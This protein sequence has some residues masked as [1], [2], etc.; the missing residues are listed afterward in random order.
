M[1]RKFATGFS[2]SL[3]VKDVGIAGDLSAAVD[4][5]TPLLSL[6][7][8]IW[9]EGRDEIGADEDNSAVVKLWE[10]R[11]GVTIES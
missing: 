10:E 7:T 2:L 9:A 11:N 1:T 3:L 4:A 5:K 8:E 6:V